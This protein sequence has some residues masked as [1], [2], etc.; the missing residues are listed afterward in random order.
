MTKYDVEDFLRILADIKSLFTKRNSDY[1]VNFC[2]SY[3]GKVS[4]DVRCCP[5]L[6][7][8]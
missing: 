1:D 7:K 3:R 8:L 6:E 5:V 2:R 4:N